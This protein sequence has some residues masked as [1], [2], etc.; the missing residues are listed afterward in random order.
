VGSSHL[1]LEEREARGEKLKCESINVRNC[2]KI[3]LTLEKHIRLEALLKLPL[4]GLIGNLSVG[5][6][7]PKIAKLL[8]ISQPILVR[9]LL[10][11]AVVLAT[12][13]LIQ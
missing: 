3:R 5:K 10:K 6:K 4:D 12:Q 8:E 7:L 2:G 1:Y 13:K 9:G 11:S